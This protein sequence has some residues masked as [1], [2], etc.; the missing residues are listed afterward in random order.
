MIVLY[1]LLSYLI[2]CFMLFD[3]LKMNGHLIVMDIVMF[4]LSPFSIPNFLLVK[5]V[6]HFVDL[7]KIVVTEED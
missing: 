2:G 7:D 3:S 6:S 4:I 5:V 1:I